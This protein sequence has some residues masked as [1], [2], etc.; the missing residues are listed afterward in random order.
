MYKHA[1]ILSC[2]PIYVMWCVSFL[3]IESCPCLHIWLL[4]NERQKF[5]S[6]RRI[7]CITRGNLIL[8]Y[9]IVFCISWSQWDILNILICMT[10]YFVYAFLL[11]TMML[12]EA[13]K[14]RNDSQL[15]YY[16]IYYNKT[17]NARYLWRDCYVLLWIILLICFYSASRCVCW[18]LCVLVIS[19]TCYS[20]M[21]CLQPQ[22]IHK[23]CWNWSILSVHW[24]SG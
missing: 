3:T 21:Q 17:F 7:L 18:Y 19:V 13:C 16:L 9:N 1:F 10:I 23:Y 5:I 8:K 4:Y 6:Y 12:M 14:K 11:V 24:I 20:T 2:L 15:F 22:N